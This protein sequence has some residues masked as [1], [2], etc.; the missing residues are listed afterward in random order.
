MEKTEKM[1]KKANPE[2]PVVTEKMAKMERAEAK[3][4][5]AMKDHGDPEVSLAKVSPVHV[6][7]KVIREKPDPR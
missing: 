6:E 7:A 1:A 4:K 2:F 5:L 3:E